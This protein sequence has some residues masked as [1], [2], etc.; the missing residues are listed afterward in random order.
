MHVR[1]QA[2]G[3]GVEWNTD[4]S[5]HTRSQRALDGGSLR[6]PGWPV[7]RAC[8]RAVE[9][10]RSLDVCL[11]SRGPFID[12]LNNPAFSTFPAITTAVYFPIRRPADASFSF[13]V[14]M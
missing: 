3:V 10:A 7:G 2:L 6:A 13:S 11:D 5:A 9:R 12:A 8:S 4:D 14:Q 1:R